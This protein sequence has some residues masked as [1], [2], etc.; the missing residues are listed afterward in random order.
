MSRPLQRTALRD[1]DRRVT[2]P[3]SQSTVVAG[4]GPT[5]AGADR[6]GQVGAECP[7]EHLCQVVLVLEHQGTAH[8][9]K[10]RSLVADERGHVDDLD[11]PARHAARRGC[12][13]V[14]R[15]TLAAADL[16]R[17]RGWPARDDRTL[18]AVVGRSAD[19]RR[20]A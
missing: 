1:A 16:A 2:S 19:L 20:V 15:D 12:L 5:L 10:A 8:D 4:T 14:A 11:L 9:R 7:R 17:L 18:D 3:S 6:P 13:G